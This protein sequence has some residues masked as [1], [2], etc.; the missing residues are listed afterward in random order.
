MDNNMIAMNLSDGSGC[1][2]RRVEGK[3]VAQL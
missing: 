1:Y 3:T 2:G